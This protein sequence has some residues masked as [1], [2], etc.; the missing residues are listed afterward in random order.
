LIGLMFF[1]TALFFPPLKW[2]LA[3][4]V[5]PAPGQG[6]SEATMDTGKGK[7]QEER[8]RVWGLGGS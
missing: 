5:L 7:G 3:T 8:S 1:G 6:P 2:V 4:F